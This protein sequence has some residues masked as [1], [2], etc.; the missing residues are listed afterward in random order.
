MIRALDVYTGRLLWERTLRGVGAHYDY[1]SHEPGAN[2]VGSNYVSLPDGIYCAY[3][4]RCLRLDPATGET[5]AEFVLPDGTRVLPEGWM[6][7]STTPSDA[8]PGYGYYWWLNQMPN[9]YSA[10][11]VFG[12]MIWIDP[13]EEVVVVTHSMWPHPT[14]LFPRGWAFASAIRDA[15]R[16]D[17]P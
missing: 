10:I 5:L 7:E 17:R 4:G 3:E 14:A 6:A 9:S 13:T 1:T 16:S 12:Q 2:A 11:G 15:L 8:N